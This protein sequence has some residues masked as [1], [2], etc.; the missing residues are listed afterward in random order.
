MLYAAQ[1]VLP[2][3]VISCTIHLGHLVRS[4]LV[5]ASGN[6]LQ[7]PI[8]NVNPLC[9]SLACAFYPRMP[10]SQHDP[11]LPSF[12]TSDRAGKYYQCNHSASL[13]Y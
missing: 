10:E 7:L 6:V 12:V 13:E 9:V 8:G 2:W 3:H 4:Y 11:E 5:L 1:V